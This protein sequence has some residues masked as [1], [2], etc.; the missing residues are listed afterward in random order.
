MIIAHPG[1]RSPGNT[2]PQG[3]CLTGWAKT[4]P[5]KA[6]AGERLPSN[7]GT[8]VR[9]G[10]PQNGG[11]DTIQAAAEALQQRREPLELEAIAADSRR[12]EQLADALL[13]AGV[14]R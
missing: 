7:D 3:A 1:G 4:L 10:H 8:Y 5:G 11:P 2:G 12:P 14:T 9:Y 13:S 6:S